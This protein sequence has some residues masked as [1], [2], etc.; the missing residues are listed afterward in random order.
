ML[1]FLSIL[2]KDIKRSLERL[3]TII[4]IA[5]RVHLLNL[6]RMLEWQIVIDN[7]FLNHQISLFLRIGIVHTILIAKAA[8]RVITI[9][10]LSHGQYLIPDEATIIKHLPQLIRLVLVRG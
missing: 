5:C 3:A 1:V 10:F 4:F 9:T 7:S 6:P 2:L 8:A